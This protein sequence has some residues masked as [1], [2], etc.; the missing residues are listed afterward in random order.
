[1]AWPHWQ[2]DGLDAIPAGLDPAL[3]QK[4]MVDNKLRT[5]SGLN[6]TTT[7]HPGEGREETVA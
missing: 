3:A 4:I 5:Y 2:F 7:P 6:P 1:M